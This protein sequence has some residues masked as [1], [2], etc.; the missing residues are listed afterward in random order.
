[1]DMSSGK[2]LSLQIKID[3]IDM[4][5]R[6]NSKVFTGLRQ[7]EGCRRKREARNLRRIYSGDFFSLI[8]PRYGIHSH[9]LTRANGHCVSLHY[10]TE[11]GAKN[12]HSNKV[13]RSR[14]LLDTVPR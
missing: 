7:L 3:F 5:S 12:S 4:S 13:F 6:R 14:Y 9:Y 2:T 1:M 8:L 10:H 11:V